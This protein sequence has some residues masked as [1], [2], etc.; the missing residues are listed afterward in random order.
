MPADEYCV[1]DCNKLPHNGSAD[2]ELNVES[3]NI[4]EPLMNEAP[5]ED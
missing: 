3:I 4:D 5:E 2:I 1:I